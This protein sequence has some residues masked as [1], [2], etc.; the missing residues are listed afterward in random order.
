MLWGNPDKI[1]TREMLEDQIEAL[2]ICWYVLH[3]ESEYQDFPQKIE[4]QLIKKF[5]PC[6]NRK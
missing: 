2:R 6:W 3:V 4:R 1:L 5:N